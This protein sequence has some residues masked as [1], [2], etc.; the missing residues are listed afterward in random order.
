MWVWDVFL[1]SEKRT[2]FKDI[3]APRGKD[4]CKVVIVICLLLSRIRETEQ[5]HL[6]QTYL[7]FID[8]V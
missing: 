7:K 3:W 1:Y 8:Q 5:Y 2:E 6:A 4:G